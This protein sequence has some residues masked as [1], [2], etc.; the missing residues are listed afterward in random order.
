MFIFVSPVH[1]QTNPQD[2]A[3]PSLK[4]IV[5][6]FQ[7]RL[8]PV[9]LQA[10]GIEHPLISRF[11]KIKVTLLHKRMTAE[12]LCTESDPLTLYRHFSPGSEHQQALILQEVPELKAPFICPTSCP[13]GIQHTAAKKIFLAS[14]STSSFSL[15]PV[16]LLH[17]PNTSTRLLPQSCF[18]AF[19]TKG[20][21]WELCTFPCFTQGQLTAS[22]KTKSFH[23][24]GWDFEEAYMT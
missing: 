16:S 6:S 19:S 17:A 4:W 24:V 2:S 1:P 9:L 15:H 7:G 23:S 20:T 21:V 11:P 3:M 5:A 13:R 22:F 10:R 12:V 18:S 8:V 14:W